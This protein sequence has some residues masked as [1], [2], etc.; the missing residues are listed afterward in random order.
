M[1]TLV[2]ATI[3]SGLSRRLE[4]SAS[5]G[6][7]EVATTFRSVVIVVF[8]FLVSPSEGLRSAQ[9]AEEAVADTHDMR[10][11]HDLFGDFSRECGSRAQAP[12]R[13]PSIVGKV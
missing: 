2:A 6:S 11:A 3:F 5:S 7:V 12:S 1:G 10:I 13:P 4:S 8:P 9:V